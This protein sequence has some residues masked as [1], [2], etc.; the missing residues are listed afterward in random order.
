MREISSYTPLYIIGELLAEERCEC[1]E[2]GE[3]SDI[4]CI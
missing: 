2:S 3:W 4:I 1:V